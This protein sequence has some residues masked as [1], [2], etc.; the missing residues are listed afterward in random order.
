[1]KYE[2]DIK[3]VF[4]LEEWVHFAMT[5]QNYTWDQNNFA[6]YKNGDFVA[7]SKQVMWLGE[8]RR[9]ALDIF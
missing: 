1:M 7:N 6:I 3:H 5:V 8:G 4:V 2:A 9:A